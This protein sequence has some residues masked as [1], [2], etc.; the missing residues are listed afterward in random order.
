MSS[1]IRYVEETGWPLDVITM[2]GLR[3]LALLVFKPENVDEL[4][5]EIAGK[6]HILTHL[7]FYGDLLI[8]FKTGFDEKPGSFYSWLGAVHPEYRRRGVA[9]E[10]MRLQH[11]SLR[12]SGHSEVITI[13]RNKWREMLI[14][15]IK[16]GFQIVGTYTDGGEAKIM[17]HK[18]L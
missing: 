14:L 2:S 6:P 9:S 15:N 13:T 17:L 7:A 3:E 10:L 12:A 8:G 18:S 4:L 1:N 5:G 16:V 11:E